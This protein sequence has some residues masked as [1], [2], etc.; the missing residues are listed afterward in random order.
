ME[1]TLLLNATFEPL[2]VVHWQKA[3]TLWCQGKVEIIA[4]HDREVRAVSFSLRLPSVIR[5][6]RYVLR[7]CALLARQHLRARRP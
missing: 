5:L 4:T 1:Q 2:K 7:L 3:V 6:L